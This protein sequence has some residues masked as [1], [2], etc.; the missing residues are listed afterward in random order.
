M[1][2]SVLRWRQRV[3]FLLPIGSRRPGLDLA[4]ALAV[5]LGVFL[6]AFPADA[7]PG[8]SGV[9]ARPGHFS[10]NGDG[11]NDTVD[12]LFT[13]EG[14][15]APISV[16]VAVE[17]VSDGFVMANLLTGAALPAGV[18][19]TTTWS[20]GTAA[21]GRYRFRV[22][23]TEG[24]A[25]D[26]LEIEVEADS[27]PPAV[28]FGVVGPNPF[29]PV[30]GTL[31]AEVRVATDP[32]TITTVE[33][34][35]G[36]SRTDS[37][38]VIA[39]PDSVTFTW[40]GAILSGA[41]APT[42]SYSVTASAVDLAGNVSVASRAVTLDRDDPVLT[43]DGPAALQTDTFPVT[44]T[45]LATDGDRV[46]AVEASFDTSA[47]FVPADTVSAPGASVSFAVIVDDPA[48]TPGIRTVVLRAT[49]DYGHETEREVT[50]AWDVLMPAPVSST[51]QDFDG[52]A[53]DG[54]SVFIE[55]VWN[56]PGLTV[57]ADFGDL[58]SGYTAGREVAV[59]ESAGRYRVAYRITE[60]N[61]SA[62]GPWQVVIRASTGVIAGTDTVTVSLVDAHAA[63]LVTINRNHFDPLA[64]ETVRIA[65]GR[66]AAAV[67]VDVFDLSGQP[68]RRLEGSGF[69]DWDGTN[70]AGA[71]V[72]SGTYH[73]RVTV[74]ESEEIRKV[75]VLR[76]G[77]R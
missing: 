31:S 75:A 66:A 27:T 71:P 53:T 73:L 59:E 43:L 65:S 76:G 6:T 35:D 38:G 37:L 16:D 55:T 45:G 2:S 25:T 23:V 20:P 56:Q 40:D 29:D 7:A 44:V 50:V 58:D 9:E 47:T 72:A 68:V 30:M 39:G 62:S 3:R 36:T 22:V 57:T 69:V 51:W 14:G 1:L 5:A 54:D 52:T 24:G 70:E 49:D 63:Q 34:W 21:D 10:P 19:A 74:D 26:S 8:I 12:L 18:P 60:T 13:P 48:P 64:R 15:P 28:S 61:S 42:G 41:A 67:S 46:V 32:G 17:R 77:S 11:L 4:A 33:V